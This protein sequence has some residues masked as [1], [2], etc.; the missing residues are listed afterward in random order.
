MSDSEW[1]EQYTDAVSVLFD[2]MEGM[3][4]KEV[5]RGIF[6]IFITGIEDIHS[7]D[8]YKQTQA[9]ISLMCV[10]GY[11]ISHMT[12]DAPDPVVI[13]GHIVGEV[14]TYIKELEKSAKKAEN[15]D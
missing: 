9:Q 6:S 13:T 1:K 8:P 15:N 2:E 3:D 5:A 10:K 11:M 14:E 7:D 4:R 12:Q